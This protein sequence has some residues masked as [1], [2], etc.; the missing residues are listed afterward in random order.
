MEQLSQMVQF[1]TRLGPLRIDASLMGAHISGDSLSLENT[2]VQPELPEGMSVE[3]CRA[4]LVRVKHLNAQFRI[5]LRAKLASEAVG[6][7][8]TGQCLEAIEWDSRGSLLIIGSE[9]AEALS[10]RMPWLGVAPGQVIVE[11]TPRGMEILLSGTASSVSSAFH[12]IIAENPAPEPVPDSAWFAV[13]IPHQTVV[14]SFEF[15][16]S[17]PDPKQ[18]PGPRLRVLPTGKQF[19]ARAPEDKSILTR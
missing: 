10:Q 18:T 11:Y 6:E 5:R 13:D 17:P 15:V 3:R 7:S 1:D 4:V 12:L 8:C 9:D 19:V 16:V 14:K 2:E